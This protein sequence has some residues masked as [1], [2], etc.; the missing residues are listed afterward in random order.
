MISPEQLINDLQKQVTKLEEELSQAQKDIL[1]FEKAAL[2]W[3]KGYKD[4]E[5]N[6]KIKLEHAEQTIE[7][8]RE[9]LKIIK[10]NDRD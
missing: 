1:D 10:N 4:T 9:E 3:Q 8:L 5:R 7:E 2:V 6:L